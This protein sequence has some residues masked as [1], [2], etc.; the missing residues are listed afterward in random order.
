MLAK[1]QAKFSQLTPSQW[2]LVCLL[3]LAVIGAVDHA[4]GYEIS[5][6]IFYLAPV[7]IAA[8]HLNK[9]LANFAC[10]PSALIWLTADF[11]SGHPYGICHIIDSC[12]WLL[13][14]HTTA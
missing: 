9:P 14:S 10:I 1:I 13:T 2:S 4:T 12:S 11:A 8:W 3:L 6:S 7:G 5:F